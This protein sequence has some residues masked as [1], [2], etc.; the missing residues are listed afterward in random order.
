MKE[1]LESFIR[2]SLQNQ[3]SATPPIPNNLYQ[4]D[5]PWFPLEFPANFKK[6]HQECIDNDHLFVG[7]RQKDR[8]FS[9]N[10]EGWA[11]ITLHGINSAATENYEQYG[12]KTLEEADYHWTDACEIFPT[13]TEF[14]KS[15]NYERYERVRIMKLA[16]GG[17]IMPHVDGDGRIFGPLNIAINNPDTCN[18]YF[19]K[20][21]CVPFKQGKGFILDIGNEH[22]VWNQS[23]EHRYH[24]IVHGSGNQKLKQY[25]EKRFLKND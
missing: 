2:E 18:F 17:Y 1:I 9:Y 6:M 13:C 22:V 16:A 25:A 15:L 12:Y 24:F 4:S 21:G 11:A 23:N 10:H 19:R 8:Q 7:H 20:W 3:W 5:W 14:I